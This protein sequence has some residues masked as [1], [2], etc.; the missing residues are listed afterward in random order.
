M[1]RSPVG[2]NEWEP[3]ALFGKGSSAGLP[4]VIR[5]PIKA[6][7]LYGGGHPCP[8]PL[9]WAQGQI[10]RFPKADIVSDP[11]AGSGTVGVAAVRLGRQFWGIEIDP[12]YFDIAKKRI[13]AELNR[14]PLFEKPQP[15]QKTFA[16]VAI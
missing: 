6:D 12:E 15:K 11:F 4:D 14:F 16:N 5:A 7:R 9:Y 10:E 13:Q 2:F 1:G 3:I 8:K